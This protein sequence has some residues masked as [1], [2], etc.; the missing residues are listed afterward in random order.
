M[1]LLVLVRPLEQEGRG[2]DA[3]EGDAEP[4]SHYCDVMVALFDNE[5]Y[6][7]PARLRHVVGHYDW[8]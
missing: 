5:Q 2:D 6:L 7:L 8:E 1:T 3:A 4:L